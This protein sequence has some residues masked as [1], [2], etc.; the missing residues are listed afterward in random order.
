MS[1]F[2]NIEIDFDP[3]TEEEFE[4]ETH[5]RAPELTGDYHPPTLESDIWSF[6]MTIFEVATGKKPL[7]SDGM[8]TEA[9]AMVAVRAGTIPIRPLQNIWLPDSIWQLLRECWNKKEDERPD[10]HR[11][12]AVLR[13][14]EAAW[15]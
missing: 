15:N 2:V 10:I 11:C 8:R 1:R 12:L 13:E 9:Q 7:H 4:A 3:N 5:W 6:G 14:A